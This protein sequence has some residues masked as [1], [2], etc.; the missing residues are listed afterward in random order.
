MK[1]AREALD[2]I[3]A[4]GA[5]GYPEE[6]CGFLIGRR[7]DRVITR[8]RRARNIVGE[9]GAEWNFGSDRRRDRYQIDPRDQFDVDKELR[10]T[11]FDVIGYY[12]SHPDHEAIASKTDADRSYAGYVYVIVSV[13]NGSPEDANAFVA[14]ED[15]GAF[16]A[17]PL[18]VV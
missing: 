8:T 18:E 10:D 2:A 17:E 11:E 16:R 4:H 5:E 14:D 1:I 7:D 13:K 3:R 15:H 6:I 9:A 12:H